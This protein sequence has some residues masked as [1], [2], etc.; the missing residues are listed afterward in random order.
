M[1]QA[2]SKMKAPVTRFVYVIA[3]LALASYAVIELRGPRGIGA[4]MEKQAQIHELEQRNEALAKEIERKREHL[5]RLNDNSEEQELE[6]RNRLKL[7]RPD[8]KVY[9]FGEPKK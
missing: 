3:F 9:V 8:E 4:L 6:I 2:L 5:H 1:F 7:V